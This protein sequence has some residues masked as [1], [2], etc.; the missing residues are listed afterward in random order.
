MR[1]AVSPL[2]AT[3]LLIAFTIAVGSILLTFGQSFVT[4]IKNPI[5]DKG[6]K[7]VQCIANIDAGKNEVAYNFSGSSSTV[8]VTIFNRG[9]K[10]YNF[11]FVVITNAGVYTF[12][13]TNQYNKTSPLAEG[14]AALF[15]TVNSTSGAP[16]SGETFNRLRITALCKDDYRISYEIDMT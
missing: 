5:E 6:P 7:M 16:S 13:P 15:K 8:N 14:T 9:E 1:K 12:N 4:S 11:S 2:I 3:V 10:L